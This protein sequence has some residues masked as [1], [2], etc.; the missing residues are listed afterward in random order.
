MA[1]CCALFLLLV[2]VVGA[3]AWYIA[4]ADY[5]PFAE[6]RLSAMLGRPVKIGTLTVQWSGPFRG[7]PLAI[8]IQDLHVA[9]FTGGSTP[10]MAV[11]KSITAQL[12][13]T[14]L[15]RRRLL[16][17]QFRVEQPVIVLE[18]DADGRG[19]WRSGKDA[20]AAT[21]ELSLD[22]DPD[23]GAVAPTGRADF[24]VLLDFRLTDGQV[25]YRTFH[26]NLI[27]IGLKQVTIK[28]DGEDQP[29][30]IAAAGAYNDAEIALQ[31]MTGSFADL[32]DADKP[33]SADVTLTRQAA[34]LR[35]K[36][37]LVDPLNVDGAD[38]ALH[39]DAPRINDILGIFHGAIGANPAA[40]LDAHLTRQGD[41]W[42]LA[43]ATGDLGG[44][45]FG[46][47]LK[48]LEGRRG[49][50]DRIKLR[51][52]FDELALDGLMAADKKAGSGT[53]NWRD[54]PLATPDKTAPNLAASLSA[55]RL[56]YRS[57]SAQ[58]VAIDGSLAPEKITLDN[59]RL[60][61]AG[62]PLQ[63]TGA[64]A[65]AA[66]GGRLT[67]GLQM[68]DADV[69]ALA[70]LLGNASPAL[71]GRISGGVDLALQG[72]TLGDALKDNTG[73]AV[74]SMRNGRISRDLLE[75]ASTDLRNIFRKGEGTATISCLL[76]VM[77]LKDG[78]GRLAPV[79]LRSTAATLNAAGQ[80][81]FRNQTLDIT[82]RS[83]R[84]STGFLALDLPLQLSGPWSRPKASLLKGGSP[85]LAGDAIGELPPALQGIAAAN[86]CAK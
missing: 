57:L 81:D 22:A 49:A 43:D 9:N 10:D 16:F 62:I 25:S 18:R 35:F 59:A 58:D 47:A 24:P 77:H 73:S 41:L 80:V 67:A 37:T 85:L 78:Q 23:P 5:R 12:D 52:R 20:D 65:P 30:Q 86:G 15:L 27:R 54:T 34:K 68:K 29:V 66:T 28:T 11:A 70:G 71:A 6:Q 84:D 46:G 82:L 17:R 48:L 40:G 61:L 4:G 55:A 14:A 2:V 7:E 8:A 31:A 44:N 83:E 60:T 26:G 21:P 36:G 33:L 56:T 72:K 64:L 76:A 42:R 3:A 51:T 39:L 32:H 19:N 45:A 13:V 74:L 53:G 75:K 79:R 38:G 69:Q 50:G 63:L 1:V